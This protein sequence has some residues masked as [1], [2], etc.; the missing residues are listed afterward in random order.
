LPPQQLLRQQRVRDVCVDD[1]FSCLF[2]YF[3]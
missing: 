3:A 2:P 1:L